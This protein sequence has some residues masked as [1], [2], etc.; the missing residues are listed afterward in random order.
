MLGA[1]SYAYCVCVCACVHPPLP[2]VPHLAL[3]DPR[4]SP[5]ATVASHPRQVEAHR[6][7]AIS[8]GQGERSKQARVIVVVVVMMATVSSYIPTVGRQE[9]LCF[10]RYTSTAAVVATATVAAAIARDG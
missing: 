8:L 9:L 10:A 5:V 3:L 2:Y 6:S 1:V 7:K 4:A